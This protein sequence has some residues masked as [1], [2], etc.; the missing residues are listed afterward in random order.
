LQQDEVKRRVLRELG[1]WPVKKAFFDLH[2]S[3]AWHLFAVNLDGLQEHAQGTHPKAVIAIQGLVE[4]H[5]LF[6]FRMPRNTEN[7]V[8]RTFVMLVEPWLYR[9]ALALTEI[10]SK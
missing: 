4:D 6:G 7:A 2:Q 1:L 8:L 5:F 9:H 3:K 10:F